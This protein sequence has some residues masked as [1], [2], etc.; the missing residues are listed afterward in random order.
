MQDQSLK[1]VKLQLKYHNLS[2]QIEA[3]DKS[4]KEIRYTRDLYNKHLSM[5]NEDAFAGLEMVEDEI[6]EKIKKAIKDF[7]AVSK[8]IDKLNGVERDDKVTDLTEWRKV[9]Q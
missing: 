4:L 7:Q 2:G 5:N 1:L 6:T 8:E 3:Y 9:N